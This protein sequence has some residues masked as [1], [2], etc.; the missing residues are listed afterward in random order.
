MLQWERIHPYNAVHAL[1]IDGSLDQDRLARAWEQTLAGIIPQWRAAGFPYFAFDSSPPPPDLVPPERNLDD[2]VTEQLNRPFAPADCPFRAFVHAEDATHVIG[3]AYRHCIG[4][5]STARAV[6]RHWLLRS[7]GEDPTATPSPGDNGHPRALPRWRSALAPILGIARFPVWALRVRRCRRAR[8]RSEADQSLIYRHAEAPD[9]LIDA[10]R[11]S[12]RRR[13]VKVNDLFLAAAAQACQQFGPMPP[14]P[15]RP[16]MCLGTIVDLRGRTAQAA[17]R[18]PESP[19]IALGFYTT[20]CAMDAI[21]ST[22]SLIRQ[23][24][25]QSAR[26]RRRAPNS[27]SLLL[28]VALFAGRIRSTRMLKKFYRR[29]FPTT[30]GITNVLVNDERLL[31][32]QPGVIRAYIRGACTGPITAVAISPTTLG[33]SLAIGL[34]ARASMLDAART[35]Q[36]LRAFMDR[37]SALA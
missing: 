27:N 9:G 5:A 15:R 20:V 25:I 2:F 8:R 23:I 26:Q 21:D 19:G 16:D 31:A 28:R 17:G 24:A 35:E 7:R 30:A 36:L 32:L 12:A 33:S 14:M 6:L 18:T 29:R 37:L 4:D 3:I 22:E 1:R 11:D 13:G 34:A 10:L